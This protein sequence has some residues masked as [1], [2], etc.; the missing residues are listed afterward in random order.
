[1]WTGKEEG[2]LGPLM[3][4]GDPG[5]RWGMQEADKVWR[6]AR[7]LLGVPRNLSYPYV[8]AR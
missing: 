3:G 7:H 6:R 4:G 2:G 1:M 8:P 5:L